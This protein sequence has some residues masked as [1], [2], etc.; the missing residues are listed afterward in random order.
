M[1]P[2]SFIGYPN[3]ATLSRRQAVT[4]AAARAHRPTFARN[5]PLRQSS[6]STPNRFPARTIAFAVSCA[7]WMPWL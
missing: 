3:S 7:P 2:M 1:S 6:V 4:V 5:D